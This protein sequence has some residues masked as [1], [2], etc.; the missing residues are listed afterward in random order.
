MLIFIAEGGFF[1]VFGIDGEWD[2]GGKNAEMISVSDPDNNQK[3][4]EN[5]T[6][7]C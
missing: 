6:K 3:Q 2:G 4:T 5:C 1:F 7:K